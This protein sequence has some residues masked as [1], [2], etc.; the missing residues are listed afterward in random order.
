MEEL[1]SSDA[2]STPAQEKEEKMEGEKQP[3]REKNEGLPK[4]STGT[5]IDQLLEDSAHRKNL[6]VLNVKSILRV[7]WGG[8]DSVTRCHVV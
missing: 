2:P 5:E 1:R 7:S 4:N 6:S 3:N 8:G